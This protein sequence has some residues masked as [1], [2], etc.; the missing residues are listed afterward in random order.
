[1]RLDSKFF[2]KNEDNTYKIYGKRER[3]FMRGT[4][5]NY[6]R[7]NPFGATTLIVS[8]L[9]LQQTKENGLSW[10]RATNSP[11]I[12]LDSDLPL[13]ITFCMLQHFTSHRLQMCLL[14][15]LFLNPGLSV[16]CSTCWQCYFFFYY[17]NNTRNLT[18]SCYSCQKIIFKMLKTNF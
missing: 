2:L 9:V 7:W 3:H 16:A 1:M 10:D 5:L 14:F 18:K 12:F 17:E 8:R 6:W 15:F 11:T 13:H 4:I